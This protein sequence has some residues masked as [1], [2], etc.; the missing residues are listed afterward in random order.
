MLGFE[1][2]QLPSPFKRDTWMGGWE[3]RM[4]NVKRRRRDEKVRACVC[5]NEKER[6]GEMALKAAG[7]T[8]SVP[9]NVLSVMLPITPVQ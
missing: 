6:E 1:K 4:G 7:L 9:A 5:V 3:V 8:Y 2:N